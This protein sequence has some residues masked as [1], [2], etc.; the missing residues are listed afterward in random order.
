[1]RK[2]DAI[3]IFGNQTNLCCA[4]NIVR[5]TFYNWKDPL[6]QDKEDRIV[7]AHFRLSEGKDKQLVHYIERSIR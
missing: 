3:A 6:D 5:K 7:G 1:M 4:L 2:A